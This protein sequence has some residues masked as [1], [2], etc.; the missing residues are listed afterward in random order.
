MPNR[1]TV[2][3]WGFNNFGL[4]CDGSGEVNL[5]YYKACR[6]YYS[7]NNEVASSSNLIKAEV[8][9]LLTVTNVIKK[10]NVFDHVKKSTSHL[11]AVI[12]F[13][14]TFGNAFRKISLL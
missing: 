8:N 14:S 12:W 9:K 4:E 11:N 5:I 3:N 6:E 2:E 7:S 13:K 1:K 10:S